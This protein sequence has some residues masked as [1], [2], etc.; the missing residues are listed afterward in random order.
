M[1]AAVYVAWDALSVSQRQMYGRTEEEHLDPG[2]QKE[3]DLGPCFFLARRRKPPLFVEGGGGGSVSSGNDGGGGGGNGG[4]GDGDGGAVVAVRVG[5]GGGG[6]KEEVAWLVKLALWRALQRQSRLEKETF[7]SANVSC[8]LCEERCR[9]ERLA[10][11]VS[12]EC[13][14]VVPFAH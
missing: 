14:K 10:F 9:R 1:Y 5:E 12:N 6:V 2:S 4:N 13:K 7:E 11:H 8:E 3:D